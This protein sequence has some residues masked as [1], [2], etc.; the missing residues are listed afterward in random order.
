M[1]EQ[2]IGNFPIDFEK[3]GDEWAYHLAIELTGNPWLPLTG[4]DGTSPVEIGPP[5]TG[6]LKS[7]LRVEPHQEGISCVVIG[8]GE[9]AAD[10]QVEPWRLAVEAA[11]VALDRSNQSFEW[12]AIIDTQDD[13]IHGLFRIGA[14]RTPQAIGPVNLTPGGTCLRTHLTPPDDLFSESGGFRYTFPVVAGG[15]IL[16]YDW[17]QVEIAARYLLHRTCAVLTVCT[18]ALWAPRSNPMQVVNGQSPLHVPIETGPALRHHVPWD[19]EI[20]HE[21]PDLQVPAWFDSAWQILH[22]DA[23]LATSL[24][25]HYEARQL[26]AE[27]PSVALALYVAAIEGFGIRFVPDAQCENHPECPHPKGVAQ[28]RLRKALRTVMTRRQ[29]KELARFAY[30]LRSRTAHTGSLFSSE[31]V[32]GYPIV[33]YFAPTSDVTFDFG[34]LYPLRAASRRVLD[35]AFQ[36]AYAALSS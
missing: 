3:Q 22:S 35:K 23:A 1:W 15:K 12:T 4:T 14:L 27:H 24:D 19:G 25:A 11:V 5:M 13:V 9:S 29:V 18:G 26:D 28:K 36:E 6:S 31:P 32:F 2:H 34:M 16:T 21:T 30:D 33:R 8:E 7:K 17:G 20:P 10:D